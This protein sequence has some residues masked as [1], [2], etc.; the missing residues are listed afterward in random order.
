MS[1]PSPRTK[2]ASGGAS[3]NRASI[4]HTPTSPTPRIP[5]IPVAGMY[6]QR[7]ESPESVDTEPAVE[8]E[9][10]PALPITTGRDVEDVPDVED[11]APTPAPPVREGLRAAPPPVPQGKSHLFGRLR[12]REDRRRSLLRSRS[13]DFR[14][15][16][17]SSTYSAYDGAPVMRLIAGARSRSSSSQ[18]S[19]L[20][21]LAEC[22]T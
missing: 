11:L 6:I 18:K 5:A 3:D 13:I 1:V 12:T 15:H 20:I 7:A 4:D 2:R 10:E 21:F 8:K 19:P 16:H 9:H 14:H 22:K 17:A